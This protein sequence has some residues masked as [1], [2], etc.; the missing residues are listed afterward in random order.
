MLDGL[1]VPHVMNP[2]MVE[3][4]DV[5]V[6]DLPAGLPPLSDIKHRIDFYFRG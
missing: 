1:E 3:Y 6:D 4:V 5:F 2:K